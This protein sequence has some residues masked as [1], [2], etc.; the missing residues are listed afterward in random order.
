MRVIDLMVQDLILTI[1]FNSLKPNF[2]MRH[3]T[4]SQTRDTF[5][6]HESYWRKRKKER[7]KIS[8]QESENLQ[9]ERKQG[10]E[11]MLGTNFEEQK[12]TFIQF[13]TTLMT[14]PYNSY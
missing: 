2:S 9:Q 5:I 7:K 12:Y 10:F 14:V 4:Q 13:R 11:S 3:K 1:R 8:V 6:L